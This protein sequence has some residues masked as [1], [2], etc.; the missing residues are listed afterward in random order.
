MTIDDRSAIDGEGA[1]SAGVRL[2]PA[3]VHSVRFPRSAV[4]RPGYSDVDV[5]RFLDRVADELARLH[6]EKAELRD[7][8]HALRDQLAGEASREA[9]S[10][11]AVG[12]LAAAQQ[13]ADQYVAEAESF[14]RVMTSEAREVYEEQLRL[15]RERAGAIIQAAQEAAR[16]GV[17]AGGERVP[18]DDRPDTEQLQQQ[19]VYLQAFGQACRVQLRSYLEALLSDVETE[20]GRA[21]PAALPAAPARIPTQRQDVGSGGGEDSGTPADN[22]VADVAGDGGSGAVRAQH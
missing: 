10:A 21:H 16:S 15:A 7:Q 1:G 11:Q 5:D 6:A 20:W 13:T 19:V 3:E 2:T 17:A 8:V 12:I 14:S 18:A 4:L 9:P 22:I